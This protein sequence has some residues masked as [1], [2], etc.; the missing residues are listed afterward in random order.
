MKKLTIA[1]ICG[2]CLLLAACGGEDELTKARKVFDAYCAASINGDTDTLIGLTSERFRNEYAK[3][4]PVTDADIIAMGKAYTQRS[5]YD[6]KSMEQN[7]DNIQIQTTVSVPDP[8]FVLQRVEA[9]TSM[10]ELSQFT[11]EIEVNRFLARKMKQI[12]DTENV[13]LTSVDMNVEMIKEKGE[14]K[15]NY[16]VNAQSGM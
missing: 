6:V 15:V 13:P 4:P 12:L 1:L 14:W 8:V 16:P 11:S 2:L 9:T 7:G 5:S 10:Q 3:V